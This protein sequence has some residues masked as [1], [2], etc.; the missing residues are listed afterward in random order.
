M[1]KKDVKKG[2]CSLAGEV[3]KQISRRRG[4][5]NKA[6][7]HKEGN[8]RVAEVDALTNTRDGRC[9]SKSLSAAVDALTYA[10]DGRCISTFLPTAVGT[11][12]NS[13]DG[14][15]ILTFLLDALANNHDGR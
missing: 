14:H 5:T 4:K 10:R 7:E 12:T 11:P 3:E 13:R 1:S 15:C 6:R 2:I 9:I 8:S